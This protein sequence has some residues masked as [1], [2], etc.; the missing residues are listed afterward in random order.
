MF[1]LLK[2]IIPLIFFCTL[3][4]PDNLA[5]QILLNTIKNHDGINCK[6]DLKVVKKQK[7]RPKKN[8]E[9]SVN[10]FHP[11]NDSLRRIIRVDTT[12]P[13]NLRYVSYWEYAYLQNNKVE[14]WFT[15]P[16]TGKLKKMKANDKPSNDFD[17]NDIMIDLNNVLSE[18]KSVVQADSDIYI[19][20]IGDKVKQH[21]SI[22][23]DTYRILKVDI[24]NK[25]N[26]VIKEINFTKYIDI[27][28]LQIP[29]LIEINDKKKKVNFIITLE[30]FKKQDNFS[31]EFFLPRNRNESY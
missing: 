17:L 2:Y 5:N 18:Y 24:F 6:F 10:I 19:I 14:R 27:G 20:E 21:I 1:L 31:T 9:Y 29:H 26:R 13:L 8:K 23:A 30:N 11:N 12:K 15:L 7:A 16:L 25:Y 3:C 4:F 28:S 22:E